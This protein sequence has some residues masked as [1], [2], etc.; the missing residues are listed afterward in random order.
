MI[1]FRII[2]QDISNFLTRVALEGFKAEIR[3]LEVRS[4]NYEQRFTKID[5][6]MIQYFTEKYTENVVDQLNEFWMEDCK[7]KSIFNRQIQTEG[8]LI[9]I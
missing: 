9:P 8:K 4:R 2:F 5:S 3:L 6:D 7:Q 1:S